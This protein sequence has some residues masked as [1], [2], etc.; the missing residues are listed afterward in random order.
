[1]KIRWEIKVGTSSKTDEQCI[2]GEASQNQVSKLLT[3]KLPQPVGILLVG[4]ESALKQAVLDD[5]KKWMP[6]MFMGLSR[7]MRTA[8]K[9]DDRDIVVDCR[10]I[11][12]HAYRHRTVRGL[13]KDYGMMAVVVIFVDYIPTQAELAAYAKDLSGEKIDIKQVIK[14]AIQLHAN[15]PTPDGVHCLITATEA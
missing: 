12:D 13:Q 3:R 11:T 7:G 10:K 14:D 15:P 4:A 9:R 1:M 5:L 6:N 8:C 2:A